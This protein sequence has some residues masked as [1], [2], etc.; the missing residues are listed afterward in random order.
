MKRMARIGLEEALT[1]HLQNRVLQAEDKFDKVAE[2]K[3]KK[4]NIKRTNENLKRR[5]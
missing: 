4:R 3:D 2:G 1:S 5:T